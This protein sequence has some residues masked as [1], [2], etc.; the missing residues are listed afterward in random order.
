MLPFTVEFCRRGR[1][2]VV[3]TAAN[4]FRVDEEACSAGEGVSTVVCK[5]SSIK[6]DEAVQ[7]VVVLG[8]G[9]ITTA[10]FGVVVGRVLSSSAQGEGD[11]IIAGVGT[12]ESIAFKSDDCRSVNS[13]GTDQ[14]SCTVRAG[15]R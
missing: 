14:G 7:D 10:H 9:V 8:E 3:A 6:A 2:H 15:D 12:N 1:H 4:D 13:R 11:S 5:S